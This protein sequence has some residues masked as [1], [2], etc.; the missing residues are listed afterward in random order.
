MLVNASGVLGATTSSVRVKQD[1]RDMSDASDV[2]MKLRPVVFKYR[3]EAVGAE[4]A[5]TTQY[6]L[7]AEEVEQVAPELVAVDLEGRPDSVKYHELPALLVDEIQKQERTIDRQARGDRIRAARDRFAR[8][9]AGA[10][11]E[12]G[13]S[14]SGWGTRIN[15]GAVS[16]T[17]DPDLE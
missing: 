7:I 13:A 10:A 16:P 17:T 8:N 11:G 4:E 14:R 1:V 6:G 2:L 9:A 12:P 5:H 15:V 3:E